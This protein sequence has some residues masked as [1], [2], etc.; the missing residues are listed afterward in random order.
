MKAT[1]KMNSASDLREAGYVIVRTSLTQ[2]YVSTKV[3]HTAPAKY[4]GKYGVGYTTLSNNPRSTS[5]CFIN[6]WLKRG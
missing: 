1:T 3:D 6:Y 4:D 2:G 5:Y